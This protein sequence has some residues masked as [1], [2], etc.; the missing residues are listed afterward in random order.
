MISSEMV[1]DADVLLQKGLAAANAGDKERAKALLHRASELDP[2][3]EAVWLWLASVHTDLPV[4]GHCLER[5]L[6]INPNNPVAIQ[7][8]K[9]V[10]EKMH[11]GQQVLT[12][13]PLTSGPLTGGSL[14]GGPMRSGPLTSGPLV[15][16]QATLPQAAP[17]QAPQPG[18]Q[19]A[20]ERGPLSSGPLH[21]GSG[22]L[23]SGPLNSGPLNSGPLTK[24][25]LSSGP[26][27]SG[28]L[29]SEPLE[30]VGNPKEF[31]S[32]PLTPEQA[33]QYDFAELKRRGI[34]AGKGGRREE[35]RAYLLAATDRDETDAEVW[36]WLSTVIDDPEDKQIA[37]ENVLALDPLNEPAAV[38]IQE[39]AVLLEQMRLAK[40]QAE[41]V[42]KEKEAQL[43]HLMHEQAARLQAGQGS[44]DL[45]A[46]RSTLGFD[47][48]TT[49]SIG[50]DS[51]L[52]A[53]PGTTDTGETRQPEQNQSANEE[54]GKWV[55]DGKYRVLSS[56]EVA[57]GIG[58][59]ACDPNKLNY[60]ILRPQNK[61]ISEV[62]KSG[63][64]FIVHE[65]VPYTVVPLG[66]KGLT[67]RQFISTVG[68]LPP[69][70]VARYGL[71][72]LKTLAAVHD[73]G[74]ILTARKNVTPDTVALN[75]VGELLLEPPP[76]HVVMARTS[77]MT[78]PFMPTEQVQHGTLTPTSDIFAIGALLFFMLT[79]SP[80]PNPEHLPR[81]QGG[82]FVPSQFEE[83][84]EIPEDM[85]SVV[86][87]ALQPNPTDRYASAQEM[88]NALKATGAAKQ[89]P[90]E[91]PRA[92][93]SAV[94]GAVVVVGLAILAGLVLTGKI[95]FSL[96]SV[97]FIGQQP[98]GQ[99]GPAPAVSEP[100]PV[101][102][103]PLGKATINS[104]D[105]RRFPQTLLY[106]SALDTTGAPM[107]GLGTS[108]LKLKENGVEIKSLRL[109]EL[110]KTTDAI[111]VI[112]A[113]DTSPQMKGRYM[114]NAKTAIHIL[115]D[116]LQPGD[117]MALITFD[118]NARLAL[119]YTVS[120]EQ[121]LAGV[122]GQE[123]RGSKA[124]VVEAVAA[125]AAT[126]Y[127]QL[128]GGYTALV[129]VTNASMPKGKAGSF[130]TSMDN[131]VKASRSVN[132]PVFI[133]SLD[134][135][136]INQE[137]VNRLVGATGGGAFYAEP[138]DTGGAGE[139]VKNVEAQLHNVYKVTY[140]SPSQSSNADHTVE[141]SVTAGGVT[142]SDKRGYEF[143]D[144]PR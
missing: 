81:K 104:A 115:A 141:I 64:N 112:V 5:A 51:K 99:P 34:I 33:E 54:S 83:F 63:A 1:N 125:S 91:M 139:A 37:L 85:V 70:L 30:M 40:L 14:A 28:P 8:Y 44:Q 73:K 13:G 140:D 117:H 134:K 29:N 90:R 10:T 129:I 143:W 3:N 132:L 2:D 41:Q 66:T 119:E 120:K 84:P 126:A 60:Y 86:A 105:S 95:Q 93:I 69:D 48:A 71:A 15:A 58:Y 16:T 43:A 108:S 53:P 23:S 133:V 92:P 123:P 35:A 98:T 18:G 52:F 124:N 118:D 7:A 79:G 49:V 106:F 89:V 80:P 110:R 75:S 17:Q 67:L 36:Y 76:E 59:L 27:N 50:T 9:A 122:D 31:D 130:N 100:T 131:M 72:I 55:I 113:L 25:P 135:A 11:K 102:L 57:E 101:P 87:T 26:L 46:M 19:Q 94:L 38:A 138:P 6:A 39:N 88:A 128:Q 97:G 96:P 103:P 109:T 45:D 127:T 24:G 32:G 137:A 21:S 142:Q 82:L 111:S 144:R 107:F 121:F 47:S 56:T 61:E 20:M 116:R 22:P 114:D 74:P 42:A 77:V 12:S 136:N 78:E 65:G 62:K 4:V 68:A